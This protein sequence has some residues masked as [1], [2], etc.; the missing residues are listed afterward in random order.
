MPVI[1]PTL[2][3]LTSALA[4]GASDFIGGRAATR[5]PTLPTLMLAQLAA[6]ALALLVA[7]GIS[8]GPIPASM[9]MLGAVGGLCHVAAV[10]MLYHGIAHGRITVVAPLSG[11]LNIVVPVFV[12]GVVLNHLGMLQCTGILLSGVAVCLVTRGAACGSG[13]SSRLGASIGL[14]AVSGLLF[15]LSDLSLGSVDP[16]AAGDA[17]LV[18]RLVG[19]T[20][21][22]LAVV[23]VYRKA[24]AN[25]L[26]SHLGDVAAPAR[27]LRIVP[28]GGVARGRPAASRSVIGTGVVLALF[29]GASDCL[30]HVAYVL[31]ASTGAISIAVATSALFPAVSVLLAILILKESIG[32]LQSLGL[33]I[34]V[35]AVVLLAGA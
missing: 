16:Q 2:F 4:Y 5:I 22:A 1:G 31:S 11:V 14:G 7:H 35:G 6:C 24:I 25:A 12:D 32:R 29:A 8:M 18:A 9:L 20:G 10:G 28:A 23:V 13:Q 27:E 17:V 30:G 33:G 19:A 21:V 15:G 3:A 34:S 26:G